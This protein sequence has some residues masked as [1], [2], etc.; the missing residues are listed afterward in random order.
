MDFHHQDSGGTNP[1]VERNVYLR[2]HANAQIL[3]SEMSIKDK[4]CERAT[5]LSSLW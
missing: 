4:V 2:C 3:D 5:G 1:I